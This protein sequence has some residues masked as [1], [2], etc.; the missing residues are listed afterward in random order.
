MY[1]LSNYNTP[2]HS[3]LAFIFNLVVIYSSAESIRILK[4]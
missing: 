4:C 3:A 2:L 1:G